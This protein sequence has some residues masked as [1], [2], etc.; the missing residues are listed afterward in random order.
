MK[1]SRSGPIL[2]RDG[3]CSSRASIARIASSAWR[4]RP[5]RNRAELYDLDGEL[6]PGGSFITK[7]FRGSQS[8]DYNVATMNLTFPDWLL[9]FGVYII[10]VL[11]S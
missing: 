3:R 9:S 4:A 10:L 11:P 6:R 5:L 2:S 7:S 8:L 1:I